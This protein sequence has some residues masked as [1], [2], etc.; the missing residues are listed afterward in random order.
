MEDADGRRAFEFQKGPVFANI[1]LADEINRAT[2]K[3]QSAMLE[4]MQ[5]KQVTAGGANRPLPK[6]FFVLATQ[7]PIDQEG[8]YPLPEAQLDRFMFKILVDYPTFEEELAIAEQT[9]S[10]TPPRLAAADQLGPAPAATPTGTRTP[11]RS[12]TRT[13]T[14]PRTGSGS[15]TASLSPSPTPSFTATGTPTPP[16]DSTRCGTGSTALSYAISV[17]SPSGVAIRAPQAGS[18]RVTSV[19]RARRYSMI[20]STEHILS[21]CCAQVF[22]RSGTRAISPFSSTISMIAAAGRRPASLQR[23]TD[24][25]V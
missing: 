25:S 20:C 11:T 4:A 19:S 3:T 1:V 16:H 9:T 23:S 24:P 22:S 10:G 7:N 8:T 2:P 12:G 15:T 13:G 6:P 21:P 5:E 18:T 14:G 17:N